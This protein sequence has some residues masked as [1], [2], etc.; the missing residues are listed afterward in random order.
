MRYIIGFLLTL[1]VTTVAVAEPA[2]EGA[3]AEGKPT[4]DVTS[5]S[6]AGESSSSDKKTSDQQLQKFAMAYSKVAQIRKDV[7]PELKSLKT[8]SE[9]DALKKEA[10]LNMRKAIKSTGLSVD[11]FNQIIQRLDS[12]PELRKRLQNLVQKQKN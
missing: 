7:G 5:E 8:K 3:K 9:R 1:L 2:Q 12:D 11:Q 10:G 4:G 6:V